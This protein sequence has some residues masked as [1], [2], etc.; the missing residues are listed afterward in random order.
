MSYKGKTPYQYPETSRE[1][2][3]GAWRNWP[4]HVRDNADMFY[5]A[6]HD[7]EM[8]ANRPRRQQFTT[9]APRFRFNGRGEAKQFRVRGDW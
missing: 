4:P 6:R 8:L 2:L 1:Y 7:R 5:A 3:R 9:D